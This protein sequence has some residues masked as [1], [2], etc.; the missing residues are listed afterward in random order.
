[1]VLWL[2]FHDVLEVWTVLYCVCELACYAVLEASLLCV[3]VVN[4]VGCCDAFFA[5]VAFEWHVE[6]LLLSCDADEC[7][8]VW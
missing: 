8:C 1:M 7:E 4:M 3:D 2:L 5:V 6:C